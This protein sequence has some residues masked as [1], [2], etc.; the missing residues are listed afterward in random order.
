VDIL[1]YH[2]P[3]CKKSRAALDFIR[4]NGINPSIKPYIEDGIEP[5]SLNKIFSLLKVKPSEMIR[6]QESYYEEELS[7]K[8]FTEDEWLEILSK[9]PRLIKRPVIIYKE[10]AVL[11][12][13]IQNINQIITAYRKDH[14]NKN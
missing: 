12:D 13:P 14:E 9:F 7:N 5:A 6:K 3:K 1:F 2:Y 10:Q 11:G 4:Q 8:D